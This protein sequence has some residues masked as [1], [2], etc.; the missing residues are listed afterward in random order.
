[1]KGRLEKPLFTST[2]KGRTNYGI[3]N[4]RHL[5]LEKSRVPEGR[6]ATMKGSNFQSTFDINRSRFVKRYVRTFRI[7]NSENGKFPI[8]KTHQSR[9]IVIKAKNEVSKHTRREKYDVYSRDFPR[10][11][12][13][14]K[15]N[16]TIRLISRRIRAG[17]YDSISKYIESV[18]G[19][20]R[21]S[22]REFPLSRKIKRWPISI[23]A[24]PIPRG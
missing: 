22:F 14:I 24:F 3:Y 16:E 10:T 19:I 11:H 13:N 6:E 23:R 15:H 4:H 5:S 7:L 17:L 1:M 8:R 2:M 9:E 20:V 12:E 18:Y 21:I